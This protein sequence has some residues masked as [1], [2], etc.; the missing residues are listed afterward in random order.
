[1]VKL[2]K[3]KNTSKKMDMFNLNIIKPRKARRGSLIGKRATKDLNLNWKQAKLPEFENKKDVGIVEKVAKGIGRRTRGKVRRDTPV[4]RRIERVAT[5]FKQSRVQRGGERLTRVLEGSPQVRRRVERFGEGVIRA[6]G[7]LRTNGSASGGGR[8]V[9][10]GRGRPA[11][12]FKYIDPRTGKGIPA[13]EYYKLK[14]AAKRSARFSSEVEDLRA[15]RILGKRGIPPERAKQI[16]DA[17]QLASVGAREVPVQ[18]AQQVVQERV[19]DF[20]TRRIERTPTIRQ[21]E[22]QEEVSQVPVGYVK[23]EGGLVRSH[24]QIYQPKYK[25]V[26]DIMTGRTTQVPLPARERWLY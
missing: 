17:R 1:M 19:E 16:I 21:V 20:P 14:R 11:G 3:N 7:A 2:Y 25:V 26:R 10:S 13:V 23:T 18:Q 9:K 15:I 4:R 12:S 5:R 6:T 24:N 8:R 22:I